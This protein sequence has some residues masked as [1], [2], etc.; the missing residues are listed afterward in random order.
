M[1]SNGLFVLEWKTSSEKPYYYP[2]PHCCH[3]A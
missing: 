1:K 2:A 3:P